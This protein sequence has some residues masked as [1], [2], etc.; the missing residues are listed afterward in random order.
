MNYISKFIL[1]KSINLESEAQAKKMS[2]CCDVSN[3]FHDKNRYRNVL[4][5]DQNRITLK[6]VANENE[7][8]IN[9]S[10]LHLPFARRNYILTQGPLPNTAS[11]FWQMVYEQKGSLKIYGPILLLISVSICIMLSKVMEKSFIK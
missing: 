6:C 5:Y 3:S 9:A 10:P 2:L 11:D 4:P 7:A 1:F 8:Y